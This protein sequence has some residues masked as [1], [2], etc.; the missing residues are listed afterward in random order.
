MSYVQYAEPYAAARGDR[1][2]AKAGRRTSH[3]GQDT[4]PGGLPALSPAAG[5]IVEKTSSAALGN[6]VVIAHAD[7][8][9]TGVAHLASQ[10]RLPLG[11][12]VGRL[13]DI[14]ANIGATGTA[15]NGRHMH[16][17]L[18]DDVLGIISG[19]V[20]DPLAYFADHAQPETSSAS[21]GLYS[22]TE[23]DGI[24]GPVFWAMLQSFA[25]DHGYTGPLDGKLAGNSWA[26]VQR[27]LRAYGYTGPDDGKPGVNTY[28]ALQRLAAAHGYTGPTDGKP[29]T[30]TWRAVARFLNRT[31]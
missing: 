5:T 18:G 12:H 7:G 10:S 23:S 4:A 20:Q 16:Y 17:T 14:G 1:Y 24:P 2:G 27:G 25:A 19:H 22:A 8:K 30:N 11:A 31:Y 21:G 26:G 6:I 3:R 15:Q 13:G 29:A 9:H 28:K